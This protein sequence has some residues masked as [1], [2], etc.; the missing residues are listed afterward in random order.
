MNKKNKDFAAAALKQVQRNAEVA[1]AQKDRFAAAAA[2][3]GGIPEPKAGAPSTLPLEAIADRPSSIRKVNPTEAMKRAVSIAELGLLQNL[4]VDRDNVLIAGDHR[5]SALQILKDVAGDADKAAHALVDAGLVSKDTGLGDP[6]L[7]AMADLLARGWSKHGFAN[8]VKVQVLDVSFATDPTRA[9]LAEIAENEQRHNF[10]AEEVKAARELL[11]ASGF[12]EVK[13][14]PRKGEVPVMSALE[15]M[16]SASR[17]TIIKLLSEPSTPAPAP[18]PSPTAD[19][20]DAVLAS[21]ANHLSQLFGL[22]VS[23]K[24]GRVT[25]KY[26]S[27]ED[28]TRLVERAGGPLTVSAAAPTVTENAET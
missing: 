3:A 18:A 8:G 14:R 17:K 21:T 5:R 24:G 10:S 12:T 15:R 2:I 25:I 19:L 16:F 26:T 9:R 11:L 20:D 28:L 1:L 6:A 27:R 22:P 23:V 4:V 7:V 13:A